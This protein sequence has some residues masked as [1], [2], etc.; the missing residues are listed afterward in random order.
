MLGKL[1]KYEFRSTARLNCLIY[2]A[3]IIVACAGGLMV[4]G[5]VQIDTSLPFFIMAMIYIVL[6][7]ALIITTL[8][9]IISRFYRNLLSQEGYLMHT[10]PVPVWQHIVCKLIASFVWIM[11]AAAVIFISAFAFTAASGSVMMVMDTLKEIRVFHSLIIYGDDIILAVLWIIIGSIRI[12][13]QFYVSMAVGASA[14]NHKVLYS[15]MTFILLVIV[16][17][18]LASVCSFNQI[19]IVQ[20]ITK[21][22]MMKTMIVEGIYAVIFFIGTVFFMTKRLNLE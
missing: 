2:A 1:L 19:Q 16:I 12:I 17:N 11:L 5:E 13:L 9:L 21:F 4:R 20:G 10:L 3:I 7:V 8:I 14:G 6:I 22:S 18:I 15:F